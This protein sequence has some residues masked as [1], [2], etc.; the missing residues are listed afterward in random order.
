MIPTDMAVE[1]LAVLEENA[2][3]L[4]VPL[5]TPEDIALAR[6][7]NAEM[8]ECVLSG[9]VDRYGELGHELHELLYSR[10]PNSHL[11]ELVRCQAARIRGI[12]RDHPVYSVDAAQEAVREH[13]ALFDL[14]ESRSITPAEIARQA[15]AHRLRTVRTILDDVGSRLDDS[16]A[17]DTCPLL[18]EHIA[19]SG[20]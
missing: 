2:T 7:L 10:C 18:V 20:R 11:L 4:S 13:Y 9:R 17:D 6:K 15:R 12:A 16:L 1:A 19:E 5:L 14:I 3:A 8:A